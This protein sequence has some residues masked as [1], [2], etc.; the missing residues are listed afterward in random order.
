MGDAK[1]HLTDK[2]LDRPRIPGLL[3]AFNPKTGENRACARIDESDPW[4]CGEL[5]ELLT[6]WAGKSDRRLVGFIPDAEEEQS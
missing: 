4:T 5:A 1:L 6:E 3:V 2:M